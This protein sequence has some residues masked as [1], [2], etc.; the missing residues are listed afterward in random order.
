MLDK[1]VKKIVY[2]SK[3]KYWLVNNKFEID[4]ESGCV[5]WSWMYM[6]KRGDF[7]Q[8]IFDVAK[9]LITKEKTA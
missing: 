9:K 8:Y 5:W 6:G 2:Y 4:D 7:P 3:S 1:R